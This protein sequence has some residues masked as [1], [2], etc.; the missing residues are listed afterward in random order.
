MKFLYFSGFCLESESELFQEYK[1]ENDFTVSGFSYGAIKAV[2]YILKNDTRVDKLQLF[3]P[4]Y[5][6]DKSTKYKRMQ[7]IYFGKD[8]NTYCD[9]FLQNCGFSSEA[10]QK[11]FS[12]GTVDELEELLNYEWDESIMQSIVD[13]GTKIEIYLGSEDKIVNTKKAL[14]FFRNYG[15]V[16][17]LKEKEH[18]L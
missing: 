14:E 4:A 10:K 17:Y 16:Y 15:E 1:I 12:L 9:N 5:F 3:S 6:N 7:L 13:K 2:Q 11:Y 18:I 8:S